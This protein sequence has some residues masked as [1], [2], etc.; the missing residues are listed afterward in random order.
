MKKANS[1]TKITSLVLAIIMIV[2]LVP[3]TTIG[4]SAAGFVAR[5][6]NPGVTG[7]YYDSGNPFPDKGANCTWYAWG[8][9]YELLGYY[10]DLNRSH[11]MYWYGNNDP[12]GYRGGESFPRGQSPKL[13]A[14]ACWSGGNASGLG[15]VAVV[16]K[17]DGNNVYVSE[18]GAG[19]YFKYGRTVAEI[20]TYGYTFQG[21]IY[22]GDWGSGENNNSGSATTSDNPYPVPTRNIY[23]TP[24][25]EPFIEGEDVKYVQW[26][27]NQ[28][29]F[30]CGAVDGIFGRGSESAVMAFQRAYGLEVDG[31]FGPKSLAKM[32]ELLKPAITSA[33]TY[34]IS[35]NAN[36]GSGAPGKQTKTHDIPLTLSSTKPTRSGYV[37]MGWYDCAESFFIGFS[38]LFLAGGTYTKN[39][40]M[41][42]YARWA[43]VITLN[44]PKTFTSTSVEYYTFIPSTSGS[45]NITIQKRNTSSSIGVN[46]LSH[47]GSKYKTMVDCKNIDGM[48]N[49]KI[50]AT[51][52][53]EPRYP[54]I[55]T[56]APE[57]KENR[58][59]YE[60]TI[61]PVK[62]SY[63]ITYD[64][65]GGTF[66]AG[67]QKIT[68]K[69]TDN[70]ILLSSQKP[71]RTGYTF[72]GWS[73]FKQKSSAAWTPGEWI[74]LSPLRDLTLYAIWKSNW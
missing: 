11:A 49:D 74:R 26:G 20:T 17:I 39:S 55:I 8:R 25:S 15:H 9:A 10:P 34:T 59:S 46:L 5:T 43:E 19:I 24:G 7:V 35:Y 4:V 58:I 23:F 53:S 41:T 32:Q 71:N 14:I 2:A 62:S 70:P 40:D 67:S 57:S 45:Y 42:F 12:Y 21:Y 16:E 65:N 1:G 69:I 36:G 33:K 60:I 56:V 68:Q 52:S 54:Y 72:L 37:F 50:T 3:A 66:A 27:L 73:T 51:F 6:Q 48:A 64:A 29:G 63:T 47:D 61:S 13:G 18:S 30:N 44:T 28:L 38:S 31:I 22:I